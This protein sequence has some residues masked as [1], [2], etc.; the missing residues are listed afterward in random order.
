MTFEEFM[1]LPL[2]SRKRIE[3]SI[4]DLDKAI[5]NQYG[6]SMLDTEKRVLKKL[7]QRPTTSVPSEHQP[8]KGISVPKNEYV[9]LAN[10]VREIKEKETQ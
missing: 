10:E 9:A 7:N 2:E 1:R 4:L 6:F 5:Q 8:S 3:R